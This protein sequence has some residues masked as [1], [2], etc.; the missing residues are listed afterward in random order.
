MK[1]AGRILKGVGGLYTVLTDQ[2]TVLP[3][4]ARGIFRKEGVKPLAGDFV[5]V[6]AAE[7]TIVEIQK[8]RNS[9]LRPPIA[10]L[11]KLFIVAAGVS[12]PPSYAVIDRLLVSACF[13][14][15]EP[16][17]LFS[18]AD[19]VDV[20]E[21]VGVYRRAGFHSFSFS[22]VTGEGIDSFLPLFENSV[23]VLTGNSGAGKSTLLNRLAPQLS[24]QTGEISKKLGRGKHT[25]RSVELFP[26][27]G[28]FIADTPGFS[29]L[30]LEIGRGIT[31][32]NLA[33]CFPDFLPY[34]DRCR[35][36][37]CSHT[38]EKGCAVLAALAEGKIEKTRHADYVAMY[39]ELK[40]IPD[41]MN[42]N[43]D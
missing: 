26:L 16:V 33:E 27:F 9:L 28:G 10:N 12:P 21:Y 20:S 1:V 36:T 17:I 7:Q 4:K 22:S 41:W 11:D 30:D 6:D 25:T 18:K 34:V 5:T 40:A 37:G 8:R 35:F 43:R 3:C 2:G 23:S 32:N 29:A 24:L 14:H 42:K 39:D 15:I 19:L 38:V 31:K 13:Q